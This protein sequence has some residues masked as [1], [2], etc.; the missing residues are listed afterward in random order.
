MKSGAESEVN[1]TADRFTMLRTRA[2]ELRAARV[3]ARV[4]L[5]DLEESRDVV[6]AWAIKA[7]RTGLDE[8]PATLVD[9]TPK[10]FA[11]RLRSEADGAI[12]RFLLDAVRRTA[13]GFPVLAQR[14][15]F[16]R[17]RDDNAVV[18]VF[19]YLRAKPPDGQQI[20]GRETTT[21]MAVRLGQRSLL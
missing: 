14:D 16:G 4:R 15:P 3:E 12:Y 10:G 17:S 7:F 11:F 2:K 1:V 5:E 8:I 20:Y 19:A 13:R 21:E 9:I 6:N 18:G